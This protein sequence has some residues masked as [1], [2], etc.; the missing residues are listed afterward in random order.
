[1]IFRTKTS[2]F[3][4]RWFVALKRG[5][6]YVK[7]NTDTGEA[8]GP[9]KLLGTTGVPSGPGLTHFDP[10][11]EISEISADG[12]WLHA[13]SP[14]GVF[15]RGTDFTQDVHSNFSWSDAWGHP[16]ATGT[17]MIA[18]FPTTHGWSVSDSQGPGVHHYEDRLGTVHSVGLG[19]AHLYRL[20]ADG[21]S[22][23]FNDWWL[24]NDWSRQI[25]LPDRG[26]FVAENLSTSASTNF[27]IGTQGRMYTRLY[28]FDTAGENDTLEYSFAITSAVG[29]V[30]ALPA[31]DWRLQ[32]EI[33]DGL[34]TGKITLFQDGQGNAARV[35][36]VE[37]VRQGR[38]GFYF[39]HINDTA[40]SFEETGHRVCGP[41][42]NAAGRTAPPPEAPADVGL[43]GSLS[44]NR[45]NGRS[46]VEV[47]LR[48]F[49]IF[50]SPAEAQ[51][52]VD[53]NIV[54]VG[55]QPLVLPFHHVH[56]MSLVKRPTDYWDHGAA[57]V[58]RA[59]MLVP[60]TLT[61]IDDPVARQKVMA[62]LE[63]RKVINFKG[64]ATKTQLN[65]AEMTWLDPLVGVVPGNEKTDPG[66]ELELVATP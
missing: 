25:C 8:P 58:I 57:A 16:A 54:T 21:R 4:K 46:S 65:L 55:G 36:R 15:Y 32:P 13:L 33:T 3:N 20:G 24:P 9:W 6:I 34:I 35:L 44:V 47:R 37:G 2:S 12:T 19:V 60:A 29:N 51:L 49:N 42:L 5:Q 45:W 17:G 14:A 38:T 48:N 11:V 62:L 64:T 66:N 53:G 30:R 22:L 61:Q 28:D 63:D 27:I 1:M 23:F 43:K 40:W 50:C 41:F 7:P 26:T 59:A 10:P 31:E 52:V 18:E 56:S 39:K